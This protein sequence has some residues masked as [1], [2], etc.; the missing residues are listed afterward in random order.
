MKKII[1]EIL[2]LSLLALPAVTHAD[3]LFLQANDAEGNVFE[4][5]AVNDNSLLKLTQTGI[6][7]F[8]GSAL[9][10]TF[11]F[12]KLFSLTFRREGNAG[13]GALPSVASLRLR[14]NPVA[15]TL[16]IIG[17]EGEPVPVAVFDTGGHIM[18]KLNSWAGEPVNVA[19]LSSG[20][21]FIMINNNTFKFIKK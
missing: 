21:Y 18:L 14:E 3:T 12:E 9:K 10:T 17:Y 5:T 6:N 19:G 2:A 20:I 4:E 13:I 16:N 1:R 11:P 15:E 7:V 8:N